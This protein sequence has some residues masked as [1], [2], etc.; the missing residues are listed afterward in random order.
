MDNPVTHRELEEFRKLMESENGRLKEENDR[1]NKRLDLLE[2]NLNQIVVQQLTSLT[3]TIENLK[4]SMENMLRV[5]EQHGN[6]LEMI[7]SRDGKMW[8]KVVGYLATALAGIV[9]G[10]VFRQIGM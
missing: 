3:T 6:D 7:K 8:R 4:V 10:F 5:Q 9:L 2:N 1:Q